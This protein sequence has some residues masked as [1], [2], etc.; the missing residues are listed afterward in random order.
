MDL[1]FHILCQDTEQTIYEGKYMGR[2][3]GAALKH[4]KEQVGRPTLSGLT[5]TITE[6]PVDV[7]REIVDE[8]IA[9]LLN[10]R[11]TTAEIG[12]NIVPMKA[13]RKPRAPKKKAAK[14]AAKKKAK[15]KK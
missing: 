11:E 4:L 3:R 2:T 13:P 1:L 9:E 12:S 8:R 5:Y 14:K 7:I 10:A 15:A 6:I